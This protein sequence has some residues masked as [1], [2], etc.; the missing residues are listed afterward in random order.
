V[1]EPHIQVN[2]L[3][4][5]QLITFEGKEKGKKNGVTKDEE[6][7]NISRDSSILTYMIVLSYTSRQ[8]KNVGRRPPAFST[9]S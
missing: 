4:T 9:S 2:E 8:S 6:N 5:L 7:D 1:E 3:S